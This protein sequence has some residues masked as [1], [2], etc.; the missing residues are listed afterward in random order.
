M[1]YSTV[2]CRA[3]QYSVV[4]EQEQPR[5]AV[6][7]THEVPLLAGLGNQASLHGDSNCK[8]RNDLYLVYIV[9]GTC[10]DTPRGRP[11]YRGIGRGSVPEPTRIHLFLNMFNYTAILTHGMYTFLWRQE[12]SLQY[13]YYMFFGC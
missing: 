7:F 8:A 13:E 9:V 6:E 11:P 12:V 1:L 10:S 2:H 5:D 4:L 3:V